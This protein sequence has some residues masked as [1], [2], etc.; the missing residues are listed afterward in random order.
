[1]VTPALQGCGSCLFS[2]LLLLASC[3][4]FCSIAVFPTRPFPRSPYLFHPQLLY[5]SVLPS[6]NPLLSEGLSSL[7]VHP[8]PRPDNST[9]LRPIGSLPCPPGPT[10]A[11]LVAAV[12]ASNVHQ[13][14]H[15]LGGVDRAKGER[16]VGPSHRGGAEEWGGHHP[17][18][19][20]T[21][22]AG[23]QSLV[24]SQQHGGL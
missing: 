22:L 20:L 7:H 11:I 16:K 23:G 15:Q 24:R 6:V 17:L 12:T 14:W 13:Q 5:Y 8:Q 9:D 2:C 19:T 10:G 21:G 1:M 18:S 3:P 4:C